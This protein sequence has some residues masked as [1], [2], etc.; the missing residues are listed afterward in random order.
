MFQLIRTVEAKNAAALPAALQFAAEATAYVNKTYALNVQYGVESFAG[1]VLHWHL[2]TDSID[3]LTALNAKLMQ[4]REYG[5][6][7]MKAKDLWVDGTFKDTVVNLLG[8]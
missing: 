8:P 2:Q 3:K 1:A 5:A 4:D 7:L 6:L